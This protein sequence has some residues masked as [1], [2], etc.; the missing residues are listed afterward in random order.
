M[1]KHDVMMAAEEEGAM[2]LSTEGNQG[3]EEGT[4]EPGSTHMNSPVGVTNGDAE[5]H[6]QEQVS[7]QEEAKFSAAGSQS[8]HKSRSTDQRSP[9]LD[10]EAISSQHQSLLMLA[11]QHGLTLQ[12]LQ[13]MLMAQGAVAPPHLQQL[14]QAQQSVVMQQQQKAQEQALV[15]LNEQLQLN[16]LQQTQLIQE[17]KTNGKQTQQQLQ[18]LVVQQQHIVQQI[19]QIQ[20]QQRQ[21]LLACL[22]QP[23]LTQQGVLSPAD[24]HQAW[25]ELTTSQGVGDDH[26]KSTIPN[27]TSLGALNGTGLGV[28]PLVQG[29]LLGLNGVTHDTFSLGAVLGQPGVSIKTEEGFNPLYRHGVC[30]WPGCDTECSDIASFTKHLCAQHTL[31]DKNTA[32]A[33]VQMQIVSQLEVQLT[34]EKELLHAMMQH[35]HTQPQRKNQDNE[36]HKASEKSISSKVPSSIVSPVKPMS[37]GNNTL[38]VHPP[39]KSSAPPRMSTAGAGLAPLVIPPQSSLASVTSAV[40]GS[41]LSQS[42]PTTP[43]GS[44]GPMRRRVSD[45]C[46]LPISAEIQ[47]NRDF[48]KNTDVRPPFTYASLIRQAIIESENK[49]LTLNEVYQWFQNTFAYFRRN[50]ATWKNAVRHNLSLHKCFMRVENVKGAV[51]TVDEVEF[52]KR[53]PQK[54]TGAIPSSPSFGSE[55]GIYGDPINASIRAAMEQNSMLMNQ[56]F[57]NGNMS[58]GVEDLSMKS[59]NNSNDSFIKSESPQRDDMMYLRPDS[60]NFREDSMNSSPHDYSSQGLDLSPKSSQQNS[61]KGQIPSSLA[62]SGVS[63]QQ[64]LLPQ[65]SSAGDSPNGKYVNSSEEHF[66]HQ[67]EHYSRQI[68]ES[69]NNQAGLDMQ[70]SSQSDQSEALNMKIEPKDAEVESVIRSRQ[71]SSE[72]ANYSTE[73]SSVYKKDSLVDQRHSDQNIHSSYLHNNNMVAVSHSMT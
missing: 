61:P 67:K 46:N 29:S 31:D 50:E 70:I 58:E 64:R 71:E 8:R 28:N 55:G 57:S 73:M 44:L 9:D 63:P 36:D 47:R 21:L 39:K 30:K 32:Q 41:L 48:Y 26:L 37:A 72:S 24:M 23:Y 65:E 45:K 13:Q 6:S 33:R 51:W 11:A 34:R 22:M 38:P 43:T 2:N 1:V 49:Q 68:E 4:S 56:H 54:L 7:P 35:L 10:S 25:K 19:Q 66:R 42:Q 14:L 5:Q 18:Q 27:G 40:P 59:H 53:R 16:L 60:L 15:Q 62:Y 20:L 12:Q 52:Y 17:K 3:N 69:G